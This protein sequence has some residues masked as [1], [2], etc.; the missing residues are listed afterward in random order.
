MVTGEFNIN[1]RNFT[2]IGEND[3]A[4]VSIKRGSSPLIFTSPHNGHHV[5]SSMTPCMGTDPSWFRRAHEAKDLHIDLLLDALEQRFSEA[6][7]IAA[8]YSRLVCDLNAKPDYAI[9]Q[10]S[11]EN[12]SL[13]IPENQPDVCCNQQRIRRIEE[14]YWPYHDA[15]KS[16]IDETRKKHGGVIV[17][18][19]H[20]FSPTWEQ[21]FRDVEIGTIRCEKT[22][23]SYAIESHLKDQQQFKF[24]SGEPYRVAERP[25]NA[26]PLISEINDLQ[27]LGIEIRNDLIATPE[28][29]DKVCNLL[30]NCL[31][32]LLKHPEIQTI[33]SARSLAIQEKTS[34]SSDQGWS[35]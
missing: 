4:P 7:F 30:Q 14:I 18:D 8:N 9:T 28:G 34:P 25:A 33:M 20:S 32:C 19:M 6:G 35:I 22:P 16:L 31:E 23:L 11:P 17:L 29:I 3:P 26:A 10:I 21:S 24:V 12:K 13:K 5:P 15:K 1:M 2:L 27:Y